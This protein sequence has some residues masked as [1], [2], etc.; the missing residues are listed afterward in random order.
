MS[1]KMTSTTP[2]AY[3]REDKAD[4]F[5]IKD[6]IKAVSNDLATKVSGEE[7]ELINR[8]AWLA[9]RVID[10]NNYNGLAKDM[11]PA[12]GIE[13]PYN[14]VAEA[15]LTRNPENAAKLQEFYANLEIEIG[16]LLSDK[17]L[18][19]IKG[20]KGALDSIK[21]HAFEYALYKSSERPDNKI[22][23]DLSCVKY[24]S[25]D[26][27]LPNFYT[28]SGGQSETYLNSLI[29]NVISDK[30]TMVY[31]PTGI[32]KTLSIEYLAA[33][34]N[35][36]NK[37]APHSSIIPLIN[38]Q[39]SRDSDA[40]SLIGHEV[41]EN[42]VVKFQKGPLPIAIEEAN[43]HGFAILVLDEL[44]ALTPE[45]QK[46]LNPLFD[47]RRAVI[48]GEKAWF[49]N[50]DS[51]LF[52]VATTN[53]IGNGYGGINQINIDLMRRFIAKIALDFPTEIEEQKILE[54][55]T[56]DVG[57]IKNLIK[58]AQ[59]TR[60]TD[61]DIMPISTALLTNTID[62]TI[63]YQEAFKDP[64]AAFNTAIT[65]AI[66]N[67]YT[68]PED[69]KAIVEKVKDIFPGYGVDKLEIDDKSSDSKGSSMDY[70]K[71]G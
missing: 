69:R 67:N 23:E 66:V 18:N 56:K 59:H 16:N 45:A 34:W 3:L 55:F 29:V 57:L 43:K 71:T 9:G 50:A 19:A 7:L 32:A 36:R 68:D 37:P 65:N 20:M 27:K 14:F 28:V 22:L 39:C 53:V 40:Y 54:H 61:K 63:A 47:E 8:A 1:E 5:E 62:L 51:K 12:Y 38:V 31:G 11:L 13:A 44:S 70:S 41:L 30:P 33:A 25:N 15:L 10:F 48:F 2:K 35:D 4:K 42:G 26:S 49:L 52:I 24:F 21:E 6:L 60:K 17:D 46:I 58:L 64:Q